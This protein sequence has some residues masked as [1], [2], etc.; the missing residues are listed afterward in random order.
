M[1][2]WRS[3]ILAVALLAPCAV[4]AQSSASY[5]LQ[6]HTLNAGGR[7]MNAV[8]STSASFRLTLDSIDEPIARRGLWGMSY[9]LD[10]G[11]T[12]VYGP[13][14]EVQGLDVLGDLQTLTWSAEPVS[15][16]YNLY[17]GAL[18]G[19]PG[20]YG[21]CA[22]SR[23]GGTTTVESSLPAPGDGL[24]YVVTGENRL[25]EEGTKGLTSGGV[26]RVN[27]APCP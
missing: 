23:L 21:G 26:E 5:R 6:E 16:A 4:L 3:A 13:P 2:S 17:V 11:M 22:A 27:P 15:T 1:N 10:G 7:P 14:G 19:L 8:V 18:P 20:M 12:P 9:I 24:F 25:F